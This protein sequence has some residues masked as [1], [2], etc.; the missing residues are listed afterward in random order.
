MAVLQM[1]NG[2][3]DLFCAEDRSP[4]CESAG[5][6]CFHDSILAREPT[7]RVLASF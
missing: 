4:L 6:W 3:L 2:P 1:E 5:N 7:R